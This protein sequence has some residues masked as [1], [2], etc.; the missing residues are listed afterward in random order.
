MKSGQYSIPLA[1]LKEGSHI[2]EFEIENDFFTSFEGSEIV[3]GELAAQVNLVKRS[4]HI[5]LE[6]V[7]RGS[8]EVVC[9]RCLESY[10]Q[11]LDTRG[12][13][14]IKYGDHWEEVDDEVIIIPNGESQFELSQL[15]YE[16]AHLGLPMQRVHPDDVDGYSGCDPDMIDRINGIADEEEEGE[17]N[18]DPRWKD[19]GKLK[20]DLLN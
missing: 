14:L 1:G 17:E 16:F 19:L 18:I 7:L 4:S 3:A 5:E 6:L 11:E 8:V 15:I 13:L 20:E 9:D 10:M 2:Y 12:R